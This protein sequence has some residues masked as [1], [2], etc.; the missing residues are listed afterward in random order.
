M[1]FDFALEINPFLEKGHFSKAIDLA[2][3]NLK[4]F[5]P[6]VFHDIIGKSLLHHTD[7]LV[8]WIDD[9]Y[10][11]ASENTD[12]KALY[13][14]MNEF[15]INTDEWYVNSFSYDKDGGLNLDD[16]EWLCDMADNSSEFVLK[17]YET[18][19]KAF[20]DTELDND[21][22]QNA[23][24]WCEQIII[25]RFMQLMHSGHLKAKEKQ[26]KWS[27][28]PLYYTEHAYDFVVK[29]A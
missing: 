4:K 29:S 14:E 7:N 17:G 26:L 10:N 3:T 19:Q 22:L 11:E 28:I 25:A 2:E 9:F 13:F 5:P 8:S 23:R 18:L 21:N 27:T 24:D 16:M 1:N 6:T 15:D 20:A 12:I